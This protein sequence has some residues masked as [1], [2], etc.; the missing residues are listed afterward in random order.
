M[1][2]N[3]IR[4]MIYLVCVYLCAWYVLKFSFP[5]QFVLKINNPSIIK[6]GQYVD[7]HIALKRFL[8][9][10]T[11]GEVS[12][13]LYRNGVAVPTGIVTQTPTATTDIESFSTATIVEVKEVCPCAGTGTQSIDLTFANTGVAAT[14]TYFNVSVVKLA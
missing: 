8:N 10:I 1:N 5:E 13:Q 11:A 4:A 9:T 6:F 3:V 14:Y 12:L 2:K 7:S